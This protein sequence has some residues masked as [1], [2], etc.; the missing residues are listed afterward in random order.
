[1]DAREFYA[2][3]GDR[4]GVIGPSRKNPHR[5]VDFPWAGGT[6][7]PSWC[8]GV[9]V[10]NYWDSAIGWVLVIRTG[11]GWE[12]FCH[13]LAQSPLEVGTVV[14][15]D[16]YLGDVGNTGSASRGDHLHAT[17]S[18]TSSRP[19]AGL[20]LDPLPHI[21]AALAAPPEPTTTEDEVSRIY[22]QDAETGIIYSR[23]PHAP[24]GTPQLAILGKRPSQSVE[25]T[26]GRLDL[27]LVRVVNGPQ[28]T[29]LVEMYG[30]QPAG[31]AFDVW[32]GN[33]PRV[34]GLTK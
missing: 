6:P 24:A 27:E 33:R 22:Y 12:G 20:V 15:L 14:D 17:H 18:T 29:K 32:N 13:L 26:I 4:F 31:A 23:D 28:M 8:R 1:M 25:F 30:V 16:D 7:I 3:V 2:N 11:I 10:G 5:G 19:E 9:V 21:V 34:K